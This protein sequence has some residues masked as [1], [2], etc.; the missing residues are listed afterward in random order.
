MFKAFVIIFL[1]AVS[2]LHA[3]VQSGVRRV[4]AHLLIQDVKSALQEARKL[5]QEYPDVPEAKRALM[6]ALAAVG[7]VDGWFAQWQ[8]SHFDEQT[9][10]SDR[11][12]FEE[13]AWGVLNHARKTGSLQLRVL[14]CIGAGLTRDANSLPFI[15]ECLRDSN[16]QLR[17]TAVEL[18]SMYGDAILR[19][20]LITMFHKEKIHPIRVEVIRA[21]GRLKMQKMRPLLLK[22]LENSKLCS[23]EKRVTI[24]VLAEMTETINEDDLQHLLLSKR[25]A[26]RVC[27][28]EM[29]AQCELRGQEG[30]LL[31]LGYDSHPQVRAA[32]LK[33]M[34]ILRLDK[35]NPDVVRCVQHHLMSPDPEVSVTAAWFAQII[36]LKKGAERL[37]HW[38]YKGDSDSSAL[39]AAA[40]AACGP[41]GISLAQDLLQEVENPFVRANIAFAL[42]GQREQV[43]EA[44]SV[45][46][47]ALNISSLRWMAEPCVGGLFVPL[48]Q[49]TVCHQR[50][51]PNFPKLLDQVV[52][53]Q[54]CALLALLDY[55][56]ASEALRD[57]L[58]KGYWQVTGLAA[59]LML[60][61][62]DEEALVYIRPLLEDPDPKVRTEAAV[63]LAVW[64]RDPTATQGLID[65]Y[66][67]A[68]LELKIKILESMSRLK[69][70]TIL[71]FLV[72]CLQESSLILKV[73]AASVLLQTLN[74]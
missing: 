50:A 30:N 45:L 40:I 36:G 66:E 39:A 48:K 13:I 15:L 54:M 24:Q 58:Y 21:F 25:S 28:I 74:K 9:C 47:E 14:A 6:S 41:Y 29:V 63:I 2:A 26:L 12:L 7:D 19:Q 18:A 61:E 38:I 64:G 10:K 16:A 70:T 5:V 17:G 1:F 11:I 51:I 55:P 52:R 42:L 59:E 34:G 4:H 8:G 35:G 67:G 46:A 37:K 44:C 43:Q 22:S 49:S 72:D 71:P 53:L 69:D 20:Q 23:D 60:E 73:I 33:A 32:A 27:G 31:K 65:S 57:F 62:A 56:D 68:S 3:D